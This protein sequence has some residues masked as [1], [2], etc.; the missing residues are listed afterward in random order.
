MHQMHEAGEKSGYLIQP[1]FAYDCN[2]PFDLQY[3]WCAWGALKRSFPRFSA[4]I[5]EIS[6]L[7]SIHSGWIKLPL[8]NRLM[9]FI[10]CLINPAIHL[11]SE[12]GKY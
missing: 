9:I 10:C 7:V 11:E 5:Y 4:C 8:Y 6:I 1:F 2:L 12:N 3:N